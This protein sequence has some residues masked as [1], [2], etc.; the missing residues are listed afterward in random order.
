[1]KPLRTR[2]ADDVDPDLPH[3][4]Y[5]RP[6]LRRERWTNLNGY[7]DL[8]IQPREAPAPSS[9][10][11]RVLVPF[12]VGSALSGVPQSV[13]PDQRIWLRR[14]FPVPD[15]GQ[16]E[17]LRLH[18]GAVDWEAELWCNGR[19]VG[20][21]RGGFDP[22][23]FDITDMLVDGREQ[24]LQVAVWDPTETGTQPLG[25]QIRQPMGIQYTAVAG[26]WQTV[27][28]EPVPDRCIERVVAETKLD[29]GA[30]TVR[31]YTT[32]T[33]PLDQ[34]EVVIRGS[35]ELVAREMADVVEGRAV[36]QLPTPG[37]HAWSP[38]DPF[39]YDLEIDLLQREKRIDQVQSYFG[40]R[41]VG[42]G[43]DQDGIW[44]LHLNGEPIFHLGLL[45]Q[46][47]WPDGLYTAP[48]DE[49]LAFDIEA[50]KRMGFNTIRKHVKVEPARWYWHADRLG[51]LVWQDMPNMAFDLLWFLRELAKGQRPEQ[52]PFDLTRPAEV[53]EAFLGELDAMLDTLAPFACIVVW[54]P[55]NE[56]WGQFDTDDILAHVARRDPTRLVDGPSGWADTGTGAIR[57]HH[58]YNAEQH[59]P[60][61]ERNRPL[62]YGEFGGLKLQVEGHIAVEEGWG[63]SESE[64]PEAFS[65]AY[66]GLLDVIGGLVERGLAG[67]IYTQTTDVEAEMN[68]LLTYDRAVFKLP[69]ESLAALHRGIVDRG[70]KKK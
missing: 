33:E 58:V 28:L 23:Y 62:V 63:Y 49:A 38:D 20:L 48:T 64:T 15:L 5:P 44:R 68:G 43:R 18:F 53:A 52:I 3:P 37:L 10:D 36:V 41:E 69:P 26:F 1:M 32:G 29:P 67:A 61:L 21:H 50:T 70:R 51:V 39:L 35:G 16:H 30:V 2:W 60:H 34:V 9:F 40:A 55:F 22:F 66:L 19:H 47:W 27:W 13:G 4:E 6:Q 25:K 24:Q 54:V 65:E 12:P 17:R 45:D 59:L 57:D 56:A 11:Q 46:G 42:V 31:V 8:A 7:W 14:N